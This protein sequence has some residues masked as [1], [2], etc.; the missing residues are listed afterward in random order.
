MQECRILV[1]IA[2]RRALN[3]CAMRQSFGRGSGRQACHVIANAYMATALAR[4]RVLAPLIWWDWLSAL[5]PP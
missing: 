5:P 4:G 3:F 1:T 2:L